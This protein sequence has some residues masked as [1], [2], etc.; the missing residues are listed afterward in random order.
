MSDI[1]VTPESLRAHA[2]W[3]W[4]HNQGAM[5][6]YLRREADR[7]EME[8]KEAQRRRK[9][10]ELVEDLA[11]TFAAQYYR[12]NRTAAP[13]DLWHGHLS[14]YGRE[15]WKRG[16]KAMFRKIADMDSINWDALLDLIREE[17]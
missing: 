7:L 4:K 10:E 13:E 15:N 16:V 2:E 14:P 3:F 8:D 12:E 6:D 1:E 11:K 5:S 9:A 17:D